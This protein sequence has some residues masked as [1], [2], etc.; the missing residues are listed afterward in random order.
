MPPWWCLIGCIGYSVY[1]QGQC[2]SKAHLCNSMWLNSFYNNCTIKNN[3]NS[4]CTLCVYLQSDSVIWKQI[5]INTS[6]IMSLTCTIH[7]TL[8]NYHLHSRISLNKAEFFNCGQKLS[9]ATPTKLKLHCTFFL[10][11]NVKAH[12]H[13]TVFWSYS[14]LAS[15]KQHRGSLMSNIFRIYLKAKEPK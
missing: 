2:L 15:C 5:Q 4:V 13:C 3:K 8:A 10:C 6:D 11:A 12:L 1:F 14:M 7:V 9:K